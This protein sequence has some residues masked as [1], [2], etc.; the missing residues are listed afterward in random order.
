MKRET[1]TASLRKDVCSPHILSQQVWKWLH[2]KEMTYK[3][4]RMNT[5]KRHAHKTN[6]SGLSQLFAS[7]ICNS[8]L[9]VSYQA[10]TFGGSLNIYQSVFTFL[11]FS[12]PD[13][14][15]VCVRVL[16]LFTLFMFMWPVILLSLNA[17]IRW[18]PFVVMQCYRQTNT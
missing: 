1:E 17:N 10:R 15:S 18:F 14:M 13:C 16:L 12:L 8:L 2:T 9:Y 5:Y 4:S 3:G 7:S 11:P 6:I